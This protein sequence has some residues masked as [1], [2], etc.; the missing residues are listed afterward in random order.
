DRGGA[1]KGRRIDIYMPTHRKALAF[2]VRRKVKLW[3]VDG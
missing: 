1:I 2:G 3:I